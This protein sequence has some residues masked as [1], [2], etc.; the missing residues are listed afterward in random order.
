MTVAEEY[1]VKA[2]KKALDDTVRLL[3][4]LGETEAAEKLRREKKG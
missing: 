3:N 4:E 2:T 1:E